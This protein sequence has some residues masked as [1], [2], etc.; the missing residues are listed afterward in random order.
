MSDP[1]RQLPPAPERMERLAQRLMAS[2]LSAQEY[3]GRRGENIFACSIHNY[4]YATAEVNGWVHELGRI[5]S[6]PGLLEQY[7]RQ[8]LSA[9]EFQAMKAA[10]ES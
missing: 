8:Y 6:T 2:G 1:E 4:R 7:Q 5:L 3:A 9:E 10:L